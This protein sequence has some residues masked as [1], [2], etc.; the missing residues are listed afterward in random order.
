MKLALLFPAYLPDL[1]Y[2]SCLMQADRVVL[3][4]NEPFSRKSRVHRGKIR[5]PEGFQWVN[6]PIVTEDKK[7]PL[8]EVRINH[9][10][11]WITKH[12]R[13]LQFNYRNSIYFDYYE[14]EIRADLEKA[15]DYEYLV[16]FLHFFMTRLFIYLQVEINAEWSSR[17]PDYHSDPDEFAQTINAIQVFQ[18]QG[19]QNYQRKSSFRSEPKFNHPYYHQHFEGFVPGL[20]I[21]DL[22]FQ[23]GPSAYEVTDQI[24]CQDNSC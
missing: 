14:P 8:F 1:Y 21:L 4:D 23:L 22:L 3:I 19:S 13:A 24:S 7:K 18:E 5:T 16:D 10:T 9:S 20:S 6:I 17:L 11:D 2:L 12:I 15:R